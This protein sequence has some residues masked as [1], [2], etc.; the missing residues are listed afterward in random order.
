MSTALLRGE[1]LIVYRTLS[2]SAPALSRAVLTPERIDQ[3]VKKIGDEVGSGP[4]ELVGE[5]SSALSIPLFKVLRNRVTDLTWRERTD[6]PRSYLI[7]SR[8]DPRYFIHPPT[9][10][11]PFVVTERDLHEYEKMPPV[12]QGSEASIDLAIVWSGVQAARRE[13]R[14][15]EFMKRI[16]ERMRDV[17]EVF[18][19]GEA[20]VLPVMLAADA[21]L[22]A[23]LP[24]I[25]RHS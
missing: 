8:L 17:D 24:L 21:V 3:I 25:Y 13:D 10:E 23:G 5:V 7:F 18:M 6:A 14:L 2:L 1:E 16:R 15:K 4:L 11:L 19:Q 22:A 12:E 9:V 20:P